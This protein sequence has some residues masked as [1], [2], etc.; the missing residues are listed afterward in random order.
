MRHLKRLKHLKRNVKGLTIAVVLGLTLG[1]AGRASAKPLKVFILAGQSN[2]QGHANPSLAGAATEEAKKKAMQEAFT[3][4]ELTRLKG[5]SNGG[6]HYLGA[7][8]IIAPIGKAFAEAAVKLKD[9]QDK[10]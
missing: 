3:P 1:I 7:A 4:E 10:Q 8:K 5:T 9:E 6:Y 2:M